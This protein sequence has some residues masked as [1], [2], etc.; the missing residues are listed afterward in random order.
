M[1]KRKK[2]EDEPTVPLIMVKGGLQELGRFL[3][4][5][6]AINERRA[7]CTHSRVSGDVLRSAWAAGVEKPELLFVPDGA[8]VG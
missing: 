7:I 2:A 4:Q 1:P 3:G 5:W 8:I 6:V